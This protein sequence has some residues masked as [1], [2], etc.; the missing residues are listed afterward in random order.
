MEAAAA[1]IVMA[2]YC[3]PAYFAYVFT[4]KVVGEEYRQYRVPIQIAVAIV[5]LFAT[6]HFIQGFFVD[7][8]G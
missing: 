6:Y 3:G 7:A 8:N 4:G 5:T 1:W 2:L